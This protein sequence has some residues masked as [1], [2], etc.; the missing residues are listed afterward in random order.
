MVETA[1]GKPSREEVARNRL[2]ELLRAWRSSRADPT[3]DSVLRLPVRP[4]PGLRSFMPSES[5]FFFGRRTQ[6]EQLGRRFTDNN[7]VLVLGGSGSGKSSLVKAGL[8]PS[9]KTIAPMSSRLGKWYVA[10]CRPRTDPAREVSEALWRDICEPLLTEEVG[11]KA[12]AVGFGT[13]AGEGTEE[14]RIEEACKKK[15]DALVKRPATSEGGTALDAYG[16]SEFANAVLDKI[17]NYRLEG[18]RAGP[19]NLLLFID[20]F[21]EIFDDNK[22]DPESRDSVCTLIDLARR[23]RGQGLFVILTMRSE[24]L[25]RCAE[26]PRLVDVVN[27]SSFLL[28][29]IDEQDVPEAI[30]GPARTV[31][32]AWGIVPVEALGAG[33]TTPFAPSLVEALSQEL[34]R[35]RT[36]LIHKPDSLPLLQHTLEAIWDHALGRW[37]GALQ[38]A[39]ALVEPKIIDDDFHA[40]AK[41]RARGT[42]GASWHVSAGSFRRCLNE[43]ADA[44]LAAAIGSLRKILGVSQEKAERILAAA[45]TTLAHRDDRGNW[46]RDFASAAEM[47]ATSGVA[48]VRGITEPNIVEALRPFVTSAYL[49]E[50]RKAGSI[51]TD[52]QGRNQ[53]EYN[54]GHEALIRSWSWFEQQL[55]QAEVLSD[56]LA[57]LDAG[58]TEPGVKDEA[59]SLHGDT[60]KPQRLMMIDL[61]AAPY[62]WLRARREED[63]ARLVGPQQVQQLQDLIGVEPVY[64]ERW[65]LHCLTD[66]RREARRRQQGG[67]EAGPAATLT[68]SKDEQAAAR[69]RLG[70]IIQVAKDANRWRTGA[71]VR[72]PVS[73]GA[74]VLLISG[75]FA[76]T[77]LIEKPLERQRAAA[78]EKERDTWVAA[79]QYFAARSGDRLLDN[80]QVELARL[81]ALNAMAE[82]KAIS[83]TDPHP[84][85]ELQQN[86]GA[87]TVAQASGPLLVGTNASTRF[88]SVDPKGN[89]V[90]A[91]VDTQTAVPDQSDQHW[92]PTKVLGVDP[93]GR[94]AQA[95]VATEMQPQSQSIQLWRPSS[96]ATLM[97]LG[98]IHGAISATAISPDGAKIA[99][100]SS[101]GEI[102]VWNPKSGEVI[103]ELTRG[104]STI[105][106]LAFQKDGTRLVAGTRDSA[107]WI[108]DLDKKAVVPGG[109]CQTSAS[110]RSAE[111]PNPSRSQGDQGILTVA[112]AADGER[113]L[114]GSAPKRLLLL[115]ASSGKCLQDKDLEDP[116]TA[117]AF[118]SSSLAVLATRSRTYTVTLTDHG[119]NIDARP[120]GRLPSAQVISFDVN[121]NRFLLMTANASWVADE[122]LA[123]DTSASQAVSG[124]P[125]SSQFVKTD[126]KEMSWTKMTMPGFRIVSADPSG[127][128]L[129]IRPDQ[130]EEQP[131]QLLEQPFDPNMDTE[132]LAVSDDQQYVALASG[133]LVRVVRQGEEVGKYRL[134]D[135]SRV[136]TLYFDPRNRVLAI[137]LSNGNIVMWSFTDSTRSARIFS[138]HSDDVNGIAFDQK[139]EYLVSASDD[140][141]AIIW[142]VD[143]GEKLLTLSHPGWVKDAGFSAG[144]AEIVTVTADGSVRMWEVTTGR[145]LGTLP[146]TGLQAISFDRLRARI[147]GLDRAGSAQIWDLHQRSLEATIHLP[148]MVAARFDGREDAVLTIS[149]SGRVAV[150]SS[151]ANRQLTLAAYGDT[152]AVDGRWANLDT[153][154]TRVLTIDGS[155]KIRSDP[156]SKLTSEVMRSIVLASATREPTARELQQFALPETIRDAAIRSRSKSSAPASC[157]DPTSPPLDPHAFD[158]CTKRVAQD[159][160]DGGA[161]YEFARARE[162]GRQSLTSAISLPDPLVV[163]AAA[164]GNGPA[165]NSLGEWVARRQP[166]S[167]RTAGA[168]YAHAILND[169]GTADGY[170]GWLVRWGDPARDYAKR[171]NDEFVR[172]A[173]AGDPAAH[174]ILGAL[175]E[176]SGGGPAEREQAFFHYA[177]AARLFAEH[178]RGYSAALVRRA[179]F[180]R[181][182][183]AD[184]V[185]ARWREV[186]SWSA[187]AATNGNPA[188]DAF[189][190]H[191]VVAAT[192]LG[193]EAGIHRLAEQA[194]EALG[195]TLGP[196]VDLDVLH[197]E[198]LLAHAKTIIG[199]D[200]SAAAPLLQAAQTAFEG[201]L[202]RDP[203]DSL[204]FARLDETLA[205]L[206][207]MQPSN[208]CKGPL[209]DRVASYDR[210][211]SPDSPK[212]QQVIG[213]ADAEIRLGK[214]LADDKQMALARAVLRKGLDQL[215][216]DDTIPKAPLEAEP[217][218]KDLA[219]MLGDA[220]MQ[221]GE[222]QS[223]L[224]PYSYALAGLSK[225][226]SDRGAQPLPAE[227]I[228]AFVGLQKAIVGI[229]A[230]HPFD[231][232]ATRAFKDVKETV[233]DIGKRLVSDK[234]FDDALALFRDAIVIKNKLIER[235]PSNTDLPTYVVVYK[236]RIAG[237]LLQNDDRAG[238]LN[239]YQE[240]LAIAENIVKRNSDN[241][242]YL[243]NLG[244]IQRRI[245][246]VRFYD[247]DKNGAMK[248]YQD[249]LKTAKNLVERNPSNAD[250]KDYLSMAHVDIGKVLASMNK[251]HEAI[252]TYD[253]AIQ[254]KQYSRAFFNRG[255]SEFNLGLIG[256]AREDFARAVQ[257]E[258]SYAYGV[259]WLHIARARVEHGNGDPELAD[260][261]GKVD[262]AEWPWPA[263][264][265]Y[266]GSSSPE[267]V[268]K[269]ALSAADAKTRRDQTCEANFYIAVYQLDKGEQA[270]AIPLLRA[271]AKDCPPS[272]W[273]Q[274]SAVAELR[275][276]GVP[277]VSR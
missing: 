18:L 154:G 140:G 4:Y 221:V 180:A 108:W 199:A 46:V 181:I 263:V 3:I 234:K 172:R 136:D 156:L 91:V 75:Y 77:E 151:D 168:F 145:L 60:R 32:Q 240:G 53:I 228:S 42:D 226:L 115:D 231:D 93:K 96:G 270:A 173:R 148:D 39:G 201:S 127:R 26:D 28:E 38:D 86:L 19:P 5:G 74:T 14:S 117:I 202:I 135:D 256:A 62:R 218:L 78:A 58:L 30:I 33:D 229:L 43:R 224:E 164:R 50:D 195:R 82:T 125:S 100:G 80:R 83:R 238:A 139:G 132:T 198:I 6:A 213:H 250:R 59:A 223:A 268:R 142:K 87:I 214:C 239:A 51:D 149:R 27:Q 134:E 113:I 150:W 105:S 252:A 52:D 65:I 203:G 109:S 188:P 40:I 22:I 15:F 119:N 76:W 103:A 225:A 220:L 68:T 24:A 170:L 249:N 2:R 129:V 107:V 70:E 273:E 196:D 160:L 137:G 232:A 187:A 211:L 253:A 242:L 121:K 265:L 9:L 66:H 162:S 112:I 12:V 122:V 191:P 23:N 190:W 183:P 186:E 159:T 176:R 73:I 147:V 7:V 79:R 222:R 262:R 207:M 197:G 193:T 258:P 166:R 243:G 217:R 44:C 169:P 167:F 174:F 118:G 276:L 205:L 97:S 8:L 143:S 235:D 158:Q 63:A 64:A 25:H 275:R 245:G 179:A 95:M 271:A 161:W 259:L 130:G 49:Q 94:P 210:W 29:L 227:D 55:R 1:V 124:Q 17:D 269:S 200:P 144:D 90:A 10:E 120:M 177:V 37:E 178:G 241:T 204:S 102:L 264:A 41:Q 251:D 261:A 116:P 152:P 260:Q 236:D 246:N 31:L 126:N 84:S 208:G 215:R 13:P 57:R 277:S 185:A 45:F 255:L 67:S 104:N 21:E 20:Q 138:G 35:L 141:T 171:W 233:S 254:V 267:D 85:D 89:F 248:Y 98:G 111:V 216:G 206:S 128:R 230:E 175:S 16:I 99:A 133:R 184:R 131:L 34:R 48:Q 219:V 247:G 92:E 88:V 110:A 244:V 71:W 237:V 189:T 61:L 36:S 212:L 81:V 146:E 47:L 192:D 72:L 257:L 266:L 114:V 106:A 194:I 182:L 272:F 153:S 101:D 274:S 165:L 157:I 69:E 11:R 163:V 209:A 56:L 155:G 54:V 123:P